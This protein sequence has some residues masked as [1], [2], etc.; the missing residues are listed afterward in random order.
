MTG[1]LIFGDSAVKCGYQFSSS[2]Y[3]L[4]SIKLWSCILWK[5][6]DLLVSR[7]WLVEQIKFSILFI[8]GI[9]FCYDCLYRGDHCSHFCTFWLRW[10]LHLL[11][12]YVSVFSADKGP[13]T[14]KVF[15][16][17]PRTLDFDSAEGMEPVQLLRWLFVPL[18]PPD[19]FS[20]SCIII[21]LFFHLAWALKIL[22][23]V[24]SYLW[25]LSN[26]RMSRILL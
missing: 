4:P 17:Q 8:C 10:S 22:T 21:I 20:S 12:S 6:M 1:K 15:L 11:L 5:L 9:W 7:T 25:D 2:S 13:K 14:V 18:F 16:N 19:C 3:Q 23:M 26:F 24:P